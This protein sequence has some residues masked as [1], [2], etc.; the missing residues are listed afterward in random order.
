MNGYCVA[1]Y[2][3][4]AFYAHY[5]M[6]IHIMHIIQI[7]HMTHYREGGKVT[8]DTYYC[9]PKKHTSCPVQIRVTR[10]ITS[11]ILDTSGGEHMQ[12]LCHSTDSS[13]FLSVKQRIAIAK[14]VKYNPA[15]TGS[16]VR[17]TL[18][19]L[20][21][22][23]KVQPALARSVWTVVKIQKRASRAAMTG[24]IKV[25]SSY[26]SIA[27]LGDR[28]WFGD[29]LRR[30]ND[31][32]DEYRFSDPH[33]VFLQRSPRGTEESLRQDSVD[34]KGQVRQHRP[35]PQLCSYNRSHP[36]DLR[37]PSPRLR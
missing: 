30:H 9:P 35:L 33:E 10:S 20:S 5:G 24:G 15:A 37:R 8:V 13:K 14:A 19:Q 3:Y 28:I 29:I 26:S 7:V 34:S 12:E 31:P 16:D 23:G 36:A 6:I 32:D 22:S 11:V 21:P 17:R 18:Q 25:T 27:A 2:A 1:Y 4:Y